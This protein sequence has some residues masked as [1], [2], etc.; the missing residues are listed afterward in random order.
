M[1]EPQKKQMLQM[2][3]DNNNYITTGQFLKSTLSA[4]YRKIISLLRRDGYNIPSPKLNRQ[5]P[6]KNTYYLFG[7]ESQRAPLEPL[8]E[9]GTQKGA[10]QIFNQICPGCNSSYWTIDGKCRCGEERL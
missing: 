6:G 7:S 5:E 3:A 8:K 9:K 2:F 4:E 10:K 1:S